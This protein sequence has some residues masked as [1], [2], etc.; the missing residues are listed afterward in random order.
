MIAVSIPSNEPR[1]V[2]PRTRVARALSGMLVV[3]STAGMVGIAPLGLPSPAAAAAPASSA[4]SISWNA[5]GDYQEKRLASSVHFNDFKDLKVTVSQTTGIVDQTVRVNVSGFA[6]TRAATSSRNDIDVDNA[7]NYIQAMQCWG[8]DPLA[9]DFN[10]TCQ[11]GG[12][13]G[14]G[15]GI[16]RSVVLDNAARV[17]EPDL[18]PTKPTGHDVPF[19]TAGGT[20]VGG[21]PKLVGGKVTYPILSYFGPSTTNE[22]TSA[23]IGTNGSGYFDFEA[24]SSSTAPQLGCGSPGQLRCWLVIV[25]RGTHFGGDGLACSGVLDRLNGNVPYQ[26]GRANSIQGGSPVNDQCDY[27]DNR[28]VVPLD[29]LPTTVS[30]TVGSTETRVVG[31]QLMTAAMSSWQPSLCQSLATTFSFATNADAV[32]RSQLIETT[33]RSPNIAYTGFPVSSGELPTD[34]E[35]TELAR[36]K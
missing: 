17:G 11:W 32:S 33:T 16:G 5:V 22:V 3:L 6:P 1:R 36:T 21:K 25:P 26:Y 24:Q 13:F 30:C 8:P 23:R 19:R 29:F 12:R 20:E 2:R 18:D 34:R 14:A 10:E 31:S 28:I 4:V 9:P 15:G 7:M 27:F 35:R